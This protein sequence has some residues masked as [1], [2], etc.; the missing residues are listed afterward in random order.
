MNQAATPAK[1]KDKPMA[2]RAKI[3]PKVINWFKWVGEVTAVMRERLEPSNI[4]HL[5]FAPITELR[6]MR[7]LQFRGGRQIGKTD[8]LREFARVTDSV[9]FLYPKF[10]QFLENGRED[11]KTVPSVKEVLQKVIDCQYEY[12]VLVSPTEMQINEVEKFFIEHHKAFAEKFILII[13][14]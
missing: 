10:R 5:R 13:E 12:F 1:S 7:T 6:D 9:V 14:S 2:A 11:L 3:S 8:S 4:R